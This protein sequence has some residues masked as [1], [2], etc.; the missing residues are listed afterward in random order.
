[1]RILRDGQPVFTG[2]T[3][4]LDA[5]RQSDMK[6]LVMAGRLRVGPDMT[7]GDYVLQV[8]VTDQLAPKGRQTATQ[9]IDFEIAR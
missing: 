1:M 5:S 9:W 3:L 2:K 6:R 4:P 7:P 8:V